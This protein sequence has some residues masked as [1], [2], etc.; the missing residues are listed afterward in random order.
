MRARRA[1]SFARS[2]ARAWLPLTVST[3]TRRVIESSSMRT[4]AIMVKARTRAKPRFLRADWR[5]PG[6]LN[7]GKAGRAESPEISSEPTTGT[8]QFTSHPN[9]VR[10]SPRML[11]CCGVPASMLPAI[12]KCRA[13]TC[14]FAAYFF[15]GQPFD[16]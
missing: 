15:S 4:K 14:E 11:L 13:K 9:W 12:R 8:P 2:R 6:S 16:C 1:L 10:R 7:R 3:R 5:S